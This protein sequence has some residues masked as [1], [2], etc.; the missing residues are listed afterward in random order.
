M[1]MEKAYDLIEAPIISEKSTLMTQNRQYVFRVIKSATKPQI[2]RAIESIFNVKVDAVNTLNRI[3]KEKRF[4]GRI[5][6]KSDIKH[7]IVTLSQD[8]TIDI[9]AG[10][11]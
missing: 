3:G 11:L 2:K 5:G 9:G 4:R 10:I 7:A 8:N 6:H 1:N